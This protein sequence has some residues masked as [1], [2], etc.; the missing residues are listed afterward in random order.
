MPDPVEYQEDWGKVL[1]N[2]LD[3]ESDFK[4]KEYQKRFDN[5][6]YSRQEGAQLRDHSLENITKNQEKAYTDVFV[7]G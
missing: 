2:A 3:I 6:T 1:Q 4:D 5:L 7:V